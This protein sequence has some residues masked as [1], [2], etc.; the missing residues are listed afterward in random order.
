MSF[1]VLLSHLTLCFLTVIGAIFRITVSSR[2][3]RFSLLVRRV[4]GLLWLRS[5]CS[6]APKEGN[7]VNI[8]KKLQTFWSAKHLTQGPCATNLPAGAVAGGR[9]TF[10][11]LTGGGG[12]RPG[13]PTPLLPLGAPLLAMLLSEGPF[14]PD[15]WLP[16]DASAAFCFSAS[17]RSRHH[18]CSDVTCNSPCGCRSSISS[19]AIRKWSLQLTGQLFRWLPALGFVF[20]LNAGL[21]AEGGITHGLLGPVRIWVA[22]ILSQLCQTK[23]AQCVAVPRV[24]PD[25]ELARL[26]TAAEETAS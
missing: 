16:P 26:H 23:E 25:C 5:C 9:A 20:R 8:Q 17:C 24:G 2:R 19:E 4:R 14:D 22:V 18:F 6:P 11:P 13:P 3:L 7:R 15:G 10:L 1:S 12:G 21:E